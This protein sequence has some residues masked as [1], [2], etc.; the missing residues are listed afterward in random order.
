MEHRED[1]HGHSA[2]NA[3]VGDRVAQ[4]LDTYW[5]AF[6]ITFGAAFIFTIPFHY[7]IR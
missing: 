4:F 7:T 6:L 5:P 2:A 1:L 3:T